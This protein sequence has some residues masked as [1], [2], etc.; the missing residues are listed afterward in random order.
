MGLQDGCCEGCSFIPPPAQRK[1]SL[2][3]RLYLERWPYFSALPLSLC[4]QINWQIP[5]THWGG[6][7]CFIRGWSSKFR[8]AVLVS[9]RLFSCPWSPPF[10]KRGR[11][12]I[13]WRS[14][15]SQN[16]LFR[17]FFFLPLLFWFNADFS[18]SHQKK[19]YFWFDLYF[20]FLFELRYIH[21]ETQPWTW[22]LTALMYR[23]LVK[24][25]HKLYQDSGN[26]GALKCN[27][28][29]MMSA[30]LAKRRAVFL[31]CLKGFFK[32]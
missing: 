32:S 6:D 7:A 25:S 17:I 23:T 21:T 15:T 9:D 3:S 22:T 31:A 13:Q 8:I 5:Q 30:V 10:M 19:W 1:E 16:T 20:F 11:N 27:R 24:L 29:L 26:W 4:Q 14:S 28:A 18:A 2:L 12:P